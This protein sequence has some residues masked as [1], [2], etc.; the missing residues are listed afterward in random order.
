MDGSF[1]RTLIGPS[2]FNGHIMRNFKDALW[3]L[4]KFYGIIL[5]SIA[6]G[7]MP[8]VFIAWLHSLYK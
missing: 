5:I 7:F 8:V 2:N 1:E 6:V 3:D 4:A